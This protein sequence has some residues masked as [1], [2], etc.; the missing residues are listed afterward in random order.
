MLNFSYLKNLLIVLCAIKSSIDE[1]LFYIN[2]YDE[3]KKLCVLS[4][5][6]QEKLSSKKRKERKIVN[7]TCF[8]SVYSFLLI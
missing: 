6:T 7:V 4:A 5:N 1:S 3:K 8:A 2:L